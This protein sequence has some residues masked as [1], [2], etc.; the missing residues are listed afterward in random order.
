M[1]NT[2]PRE[3]TVE[4]EFLADGAVEASLD[5][6]GAV[7]L[8]PGESIEVAAMIANFA[9]GKPVSAMLVARRAD[10][11]RAS[12]A[13]ELVEP[14]ASS[15]DLD[16][17]GV[18]SGADLALLLGNFGGSGL[19]DLDGSGEVDGADLAILL[20]AWKNAGS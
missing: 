10:E 11:A 18:V 3:A 12:A 5:P 13:I 2:G 15:P 14:S 6:I 9:G 19:G 16:G 7:L 4:F 8:A 20:G 17:D 1:T